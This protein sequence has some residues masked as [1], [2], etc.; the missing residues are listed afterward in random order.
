[1]N[2]GKLISFIDLSAGL[3]IQRLYTQ[4]RRKPLKK[5]VRL[6]CKHQGGF[7]SENLVLDIWR[8][9]SIP[10]FPLLPDPLCPGVL[11]PV[12]VRSMSKTEKI[13]KKQ[14]HKNVNMNVQ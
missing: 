2:Q 13:L 14:E 12:W 10:S 4:P 6:K 5:R 9:W 8:V 11:V 3:R 7:D 1:M